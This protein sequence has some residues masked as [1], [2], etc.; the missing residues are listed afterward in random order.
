[1]RSAP[2]KTARRSS[3]RSRRPTGFGVVAYD[4]DGSVTDIVEKAGIV[5]KRYEEPPSTTRSSASTATAGCVRDHRR[6]RASSRGELEINGR[7]TASTRGAAASPCTVSKVG[8]RR[9]QALG[10]SSRRSGRRSKRRASTSD[11]RSL[12]AHSRR[13]NMFPLVTASSGMV[14]RTSRFPTAPPHESLSEP[15]PPVGSSTR[16][17]LNAARDERVFSV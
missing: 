12:F 6:A 16:F 13:G 9:R 14:G 11:R 1:M 3:S 17:P 2:G 7:L 10:R 8:A 4:G 5:D 15:G